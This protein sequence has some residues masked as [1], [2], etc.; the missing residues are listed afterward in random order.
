[1]CSKALPF[2]RQLLRWGLTHGLE[3]LGLCGGAREEF[4][5][6]LAVQCTLRKT[7]LACGPQQAAPCITEAAFELII[8]PREAWHVIAVK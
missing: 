8:G 3:S 6:A 5:R 4:P 2:L 1:M 7:F